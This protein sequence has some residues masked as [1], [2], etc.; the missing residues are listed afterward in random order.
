[1]RNRH[2]VAF[3]LI[4]LLVVIS[5]IVLLI[6]I[7]LP[8]LA[9]AR[10]AAMKLQC[11]NNVRSMTQMAFIYAADNRE[12]LPVRG[13]TTAYT[14]LVGMW[15]IG[16]MD[17][18]GFSIDLAFCPLGCVDEDR[19][20]AFYALLGG[21]LGYA[22]LGAHNP[23]GLV[24]GHNSPVTTADTIDNTGA[25]SVLFADVSRYNDTAA[26][27]PLATNHAAEGEVVEDFF[28]YGTVGI[29]Q[30]QYQSYMDGSVHWLAREDYDLT[31]W[32]YTRPLDPGADYSFH[33]R[34]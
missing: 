23:D 30:G 20:V 2:H 17:D 18:Y 21:G 6:A 5:I 25:P 12:V 11:S 26:T 3:T 22:Y 28:G 33:W 13:P 10:E 31:A 9:K 7:L 14:N 29:A 24:N 15:F 34:K 32:S 4:E 1:M 16:G 8:S 19:K 27:D